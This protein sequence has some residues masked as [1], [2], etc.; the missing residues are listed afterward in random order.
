MLKLN[1][2]VKLSKLDQKKIKG[3]LD[4]IDELPG[5][6][7]G[8]QCYD[9]CSSDAQCPQ[10]GSMCQTYDCIYGGTTKLCTRGY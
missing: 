10:R 1:G 5:E 8:G 3:G 4:P 6:G 9:R 7:G 2:L